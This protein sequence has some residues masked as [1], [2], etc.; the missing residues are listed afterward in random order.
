MVLSAFCICVQFIPLPWT[1]VGLTAQEPPPPPPQPPPQILSESWTSRSHG[2]SRSEM[3]QFYFRSLTLYISLHPKCQAAAWLLCL[4]PVQL[5]PSSQIAPGKKTSLTSM[6]Y[7][8]CRL[9]RLFSLLH[10][11]CLLC[12]CADHSVHGVMSVCCSPLLTETQWLSPCLAEYAVQGW[13]HGAMPV[14]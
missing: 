7:F 13:H 8:S 2:P 9:R 3:F 6:D 10:V 1:S 11:V 14:Y 5:S 12:Y 4:F